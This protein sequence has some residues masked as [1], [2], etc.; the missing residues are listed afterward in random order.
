MPE[1]IMGSIRAFNVLCK[2][3]QVGKCHS[4]QQIMSL[5]DVGS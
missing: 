5:S 1:Q 4:M 2:K 3:F